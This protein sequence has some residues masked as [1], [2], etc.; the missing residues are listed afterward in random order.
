M[1]LNL[2]NCGPPKLFWGSLMNH[3]IYLSGIKMVGFPVFRLYSGDLTSNLVWIL[4]GLKEVG[5]NGRD[6]EWDLKSGSPTN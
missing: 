3:K 1:F 5:A 6:F 2:F 4:K